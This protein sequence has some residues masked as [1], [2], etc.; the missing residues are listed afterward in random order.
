MKRTVIGILA[1]VDAGKTTLAEAI[2][3]RSGKIRKQGSVDDGTTSLD[4]HD[5][6]RERGITIFAHEA[7]FD[8]GDTVV[9]LLDTPGHVDF[10]AEMERTLSVLDCAIVVISGAEGVQSHTRTVWKLLSLYNVPTFIFVSKMAYA[11]RT[12]AEL[13]REFAEEL[14]PACLDFSADA[15]TS[16]R[17]EEISL[18]REDLLEKYLSGV[19]FTD[20]DI[21]SLVRTRLVFPC[22]FGSGRTLAGV[23]DFLSVLARWQPVPDYRSETAARVFRVTHD[24][25]KRLVHVKVTGGTLRVRDLFGEEKIS[26]LRVYSGEKYFAVPEMSAGGVCAVVGLSKP[27]AGEGLGADAD[28]RSHAPVLEPVMQYRIVLPMQED[29]AVVLPKLRTLTEEDPLL[30]IGYDTRTG[31]ITASLMGEVQAEILKSVILARFGIPVVIDRG[32]ILYKETIADETSVE[33]VGHY[34]PLRHYAEV[35]LL[36]SP[37]PRGTGIKVQSQC[38]ENSLALNWQRLILTHLLEKEHRGVLTGA[39]LTDVMIS[40]AS[41]RA[42][43]KHTEGG[44]FRQATYRAVRQGLMRAKSVLLEPFVSFRLTVPVDRLGRAVNDLR[45]RSAFISSQEIGETTAVLEG[46]SPVAT[47]NDYAPLLAGYTGGTGKLFLTPDGYDLCHDAERVIAAV[48]YQPTRDLDNTPD[49]VFCAHGAGFVVPWDKVP[50]YMHLESVLKKKSDDM[51]RVHRTLNID[52]AELEAIM[53]REF[54]PIRRPTYKPAVV[55]ASE[56]EIDLKLTERPKTLIVDGYNVIF[57]WSDLND[58]AKNDLEAAREKLMHLLANYA[59]YTR[60]DVVLVFDA[61]K[62]PGGKGE[63]FD[64]HRVHVAYTKENETGD[65][66]IERLTSQIGKNERVRVVTSDGLIQLTAVRVGVM[67][68]S[69][70]EFGEE[71]DAVCAEIEDLIARSGDTKNSTIAEL[72]ANSTPRT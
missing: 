18:L 30:R 55:V 44:D 38:S 10:S 34:E 45:E 1:H 24:G 43:L 14:S 8:L 5:L 13:L 2:L 3:Y 65:A 40:V 21:A 4:T 31:E 50:Q 15:N 62:V 49:S 71:M 25:D 39:P 11:R 51:P 36:L 17:D 47:I 22:F 60:C 70:R 41:G 59:A 27:Q 63:K 7:T 26:E 9:T 33:G 48:G 54:G 61:Y 69:A 46:R 28:T 19:P 57:A 58:L 35:H 32:R 53:L 64:Y 16:A 6:E 52:D 20:D 67:R 72:I 68:M 56:E 37:L 23:D 12:R 29:A 42:H 66:Y